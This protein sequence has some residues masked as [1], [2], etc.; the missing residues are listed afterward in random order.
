MFFESPEFFTSSDSL[1]TLKA[2]RVPDTTNLTEK[3]HTLEHILQKFYD[4]IWCNHQ[5]KTY[6]SYQFLSYITIKIHAIY[7][8]LHTQ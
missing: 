4:L 2:L 6:F 3:M 5:T 7:I 8:T 1:C